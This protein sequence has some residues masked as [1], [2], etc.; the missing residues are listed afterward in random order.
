M[1]SVSPAQVRSLLLSHLQLPLSQK[2]LNPED[3]RDDFDLLT[4]GVVD[5]QGVLELIVEIE[6]RLGV[7]INFEE[8]DPESLTV[9]GPLCLY[10]SDRSSGNEA[11][12]Q[13]VPEMNNMA[14]G[15]GEPGTAQDA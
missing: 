11:G 6:E 13:S 3:I 15:T 14:L 9:V 7:T 1:N 12:T 4:Q 5:S 2:G 8:M 10:V